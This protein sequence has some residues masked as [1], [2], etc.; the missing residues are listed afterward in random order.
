M[1]GSFDNWNVIQSTNEKTENDDFDAV[2]KVVL[3][4]ISDNMSALIHNGKYGVINTADQT[5]MGYYIFKL[6][7][8]P[9][10]F[11]RRIFFTSNS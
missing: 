2:N 3:D 4:G 8:E 1:L 10:M 11:T 7:S 9:Y 6:L 5:T